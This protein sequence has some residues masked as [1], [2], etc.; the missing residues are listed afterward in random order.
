MYDES[1]HTLATETYKYGI[2]LMLASLIP[3]IIALVHVY[4]TNPSKNQKNSHTSN[5]LLWIWMLMILSVIFFPMVQIY[6]YILLI[7][8]PA[9]TPDEKNKLKESIYNHWIL[10]DFYPFKEN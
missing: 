6:F 2:Y 9:D 8:L 3:T 7:I 4:L 1:N 5:S 10:F